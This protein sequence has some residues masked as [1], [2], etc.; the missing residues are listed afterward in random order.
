MSLIALVAGSC[1]AVVF[2]WGALAKLVRFPEWQQALEA[3]RLPP[4]ASVPA[5]AGVPVA[6]LA[7]VGMLFSGRALA[8]SALTLMLLAVFSLALL[9][10]RQKGGDRLP[11]GCF[12]KATLHD[13]RLL[14]A[15]NAGLA[16]LAGLVLISG[17]DRLL[18]D[19]AVAAPTNLVPVGLV[20]VGGVLLFRVVREA[21]GAMRRP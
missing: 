8:A 15:R 5:S 3:Y 14:V 18:G 4:A 2:G 19:S 12:G 10:A 20:A 1:L 7:V 13:L 21:A 11:C 17:H 6:E 9:S 16:F